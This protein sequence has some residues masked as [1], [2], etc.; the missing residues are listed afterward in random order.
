MRKKT[1]SPPSDFTSAAADIPS[2]DAKPVTT[3]IAPTQMMS[4]Q[5]DVPS[6]YFVNG[7]FDHPISPITF[8]RSVVAESQIATPR[9]SDGTSPQPKIFVPTS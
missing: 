8:A 3:A 2:P 7:R 4:S 1:V 5:T 9:K 6:T